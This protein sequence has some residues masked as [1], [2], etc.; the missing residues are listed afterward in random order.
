MG[1]V[2]VRAV[3]AAVLLVLHLLSCAPGPHLDTGA[4]IVHSHGEMPGEADVHPSC[5]VVVAPS[6]V[7]HEPAAV[8]YVPEPAVAE[9]AVVPEFAVGFAAIPPDPSHSRAQSVLCVWRN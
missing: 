4:G 8:A 6:H 1:G 2:V 3:V 9:T 5:D 7:S